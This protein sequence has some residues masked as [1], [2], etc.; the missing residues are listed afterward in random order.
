M[1]DDLKSIGECG[2][3]PDTLPYRS[4]LL[5][6]WFEN[7]LLR[8]VTEA[9]CRS[10][11]QTLWK[12]KRLKWASHKNHNSARCTCDLRLSRHF[13]VF[14]KDF[15]GFISDFMASNTLVFQRDATA[16]QIKV[17]FCDV[18]L[19][20]IKRRSMFFPPSTS[21]ARQYFL[22]TLRNYN[23]AK[24]LPDC[25]P[26]I[27]TNRVE[28]LSAKTWFIMKWTRSISELAKDLFRFPILL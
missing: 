26:V 23:L 22:S 19:F 28:C 15:G 4:V 6:L 18:K 5:P 16:E 11:F 2:Y 13:S 8:M 14:W 3:C 10:G 20:E 7:N 1:Y 21:L 27:T 12:P 25:A 9:S 17:C 24:L